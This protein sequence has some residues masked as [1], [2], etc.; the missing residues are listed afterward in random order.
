MTKLFKDCGEIYVS[1]KELRTLTDLGIPQK[2]ALFTA[3]L[4]FV[5]PWCCNEFRQ[6][7]NLGENVGH[8]GSHSSL[9]ARALCYCV[10]GSEAKVSVI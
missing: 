6:T 3:F 7:W 9:A 2:S 4:C 10:C 1:L 8:N 5:D